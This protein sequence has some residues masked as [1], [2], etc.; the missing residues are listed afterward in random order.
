MKTSNNKNPSRLSR[1]IFKKR[2]IALHHHHLFG[3]A[4]GAQACF[5]DGCVAHQDHR[6]R[7]MVAVAENDAY[8]LFQHDKRIKKF[9]GQFIILLAGM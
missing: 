5:A 1:R 6:A 7:Y 8:G 4:K 2:M 9:R 3:A